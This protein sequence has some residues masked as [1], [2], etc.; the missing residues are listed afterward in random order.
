M[1]LTFCLLGRNMRA[2]LRGLLLALLLSF[3]QGVQAVSISGSE[4]NLSNE[5]PNSFVQVL[6]DSASGNMLPRAEHTA[7]WRYKPSYQLGYYAVMWHA[8]N[9]GAWDQGAYSYG[10]HPYPADNCNVNSIGQ[11]VGGSGSS[12]TNHCWE[13]AGLMGGPHGPGADYLATAGGG[14]GVVV[15]PGLWYVQIRRVR[16]MTSGPHAGEY[17]HR[18]LPD[19][20]NNPSFEIVQYITDIY[21]PDGGNPANYFGISDWSGVAAGGN[22]ETLYGVIRG[23][24]MY[25]AYL[26]DADAATEAGNQLSNSPLTAAGIANTWYMN[27]NPIPTDWNDKSGAGHH[28]TWGTANRPIQWDSTLSAP[29]WGVFGDNDMMLNKVG[30]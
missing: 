25:D 6:W 15:V 23:V 17:E 12:G 9:N 27:Q 3:A 13:E 7:I 1:L 2:T 5:T 4:W 14:P 29:R 21:P 16:L 10:T 18:F 20:L 19:L 11:T 22:G 8:P 26:S 28:P 30:F 24:Q